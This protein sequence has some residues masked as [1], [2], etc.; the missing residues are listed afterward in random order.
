MNIYFN[1]GKESGPWGTKIIALAAIARQKGFR[2]V[3][4]NYSNQPDPDTRIEELLNLRLPD[5]EFTVLVGSSMGGYVATV[6]SQI[7]TPVGLFLMAPAFYLPG[8]K[9]QSPTPHARKTVIIHGLKDEIVPVENSIRFA[10]EHSTE[11]HLIDGDHSLNDQLPK[12]EMLFGLFL[13]EILGRSEPPKILELDEPPK[14]LTWEEISQKFAIKEDN[15]VARMW[16]ALI[17]GGHAQYSN[18]SERIITMLEFFALANFYHAFLSDFSQFPCHSNL[19]VTA[20]NL[21]ISNDVFE[22]L[23]ADFAARHSNFNDEKVII[24]MELEDIFRENVYLTLLEQ[25]HRGSS[26]ALADSLLEEAYPTI[27]DDYVEDNEYVNDSVDPYSWQLRDDDSVDDDPVE[28]DSNELWY[29]D[30]LLDPE[31]FDAEVFSKKPTIEIIHEWLLYRLNPP[32]NNSQT[33]AKSEIITS[34]AYHQC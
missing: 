23:L 13:D 10:R 31:D 7:I 18:E 21:D 5:S 14:I 24:Q 17:S 34:L 9:D 32:E 16:E 33:G 1:H 27:Y 30:Y 15:W 3:S 11:L 29:N 22:Q 6:A 8:Y 2:V 26:I 25:C 12:I 28:P 20:E 4:P 19:Q